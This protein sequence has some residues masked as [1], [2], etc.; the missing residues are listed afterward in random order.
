MGRFNHSL[1]PYLLDHQSGLPASVSEKKNRETQFPISN[2]KNGFPYPW[3]YT[4][5]EHGKPH[6]PSRRFTANTYPTSG[7]RD[8]EKLY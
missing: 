7:I 8:L 5:F 6:H 4:F 2:V 1:D 3:I